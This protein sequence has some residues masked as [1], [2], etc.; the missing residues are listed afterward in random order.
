MNNK[1]WERIDPY[2]INGACK[3]WNSVDAQQKASHPREG[4]PLSAI[5]VCLNCPLPD[6]RGCDPR[7]GPPKPRRKTT[8]LD[9]IGEKLFAQGKTDREVAEMLRISRNTVTKWRR[10]NGVTAGKF[11][12]AGRNGRKHETNYRR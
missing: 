3:P 10:L 5:R 11:Q 8:P 2:G 6:C 12:K 4:D 1:S 7:K 9:G